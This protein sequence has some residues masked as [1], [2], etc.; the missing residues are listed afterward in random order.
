MGISVTFCGAAGEV[1]GSCHLVRAGRYQLL[2]D[3]G[4]IQ[5]NP[6]AERRNHDPF[7]FDPAAIDAVILSH[8]HIDHSGR[9]P[10]LTKRGFSGSVHT[11]SACRDLCAIMLAD[12]GYLNERETEWQNRKRRRKGLRPLEALYTMADAK[13]ALDRFV[14]MD[15][16]V[17][18]EILPGISV[19]LRDAGHILGSSI[20]EL[21]VRDGPSERKIVF[22]GDLGHRGA[23][24]LRDPCPVRRADVVILESTYGDRQHRPWEQ[25]Y[26]EFGEVLAKAADSR[27]NV[28]IPSFAI[29]RS[30]E[31]IYLFATYFDAWGL[32]RWQVFL[33]SPMAI[34]ATQVYAR[35]R[36]HYDDEATALL[37]RVK[38]GETLLPN[39]HFS[40][41]AEESQM[42][43]RI[44][45]GAIIIAAS[46]MCEGGRVKHHLKHNVWRNNCD[47]VFVGFQAQGT[48]GRSLVDGARFIRL[49]GETI[50]VA[51]RVHT[52]G[53]FSAHAD[54]V[55]LGDW[56]SHFEGQPDVYLVHGEDTPRAALRETLERRGL[57]PVRLPKLGETVSL[58]N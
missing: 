45:S 33:D 20:V 47:V 4:L 48:L 25:T 34:E 6:A 1:T 36:R 43:N 53:G 37:K 5:G 29:G 26:R 3:C 14:G 16:D 50:R 24:I 49:W 12:C 10:L 58:S 32:D 17:R 15:Y 46:G 57:K 22:S 23:P 9:L 11:E 44:N 35:Y 21:W 39:L 31:L 28:L 56:C 27:G 55:A 2:L 42:I 40:R 18:R 52:I 30:Q 41:T 7:P 38:V 19:R 8:A 13:K 54:Q 51:A